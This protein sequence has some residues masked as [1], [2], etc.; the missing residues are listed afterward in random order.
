MLFL[1]FLLGLIWGSFLNVVIYRL[2]RDLSL[3]KPGSRCPY[4]G[5]ALGFQELIPLLSFLIQKG[6]CKACGALISWRYFLIELLSGLGFAA[7]GL[8]ATSFFES[9]VGLAFFSFLLTS[10]FIDLEHKLLLNVLTIPGLVLGLAFSLLSWSIPF[11]AALAGA[12]A[13]FV[14]I[15]LIILISR[16]GMG[17]GDAKFMALIGAFLGWQKVFYVLFSASLFGTLA[18]L[19]Y[20]FLTKQGRKT[21]IPFGPFLALAAFILYFY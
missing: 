15:F 12:A 5:Q 4:C 16:G 1:L 17:L 9:V 21:P 14:I 13:G 10:A 3:L 8:T 2:P 18:G 7:V 11:S 6:R 19:T 20:L